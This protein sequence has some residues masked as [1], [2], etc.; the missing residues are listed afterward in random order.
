MIIKQLSVFLE[1]KSGRLTELTDVLGEAG[2]NLSA[3]SIAE[4]SEFGII[5]MVVSDPEKGLQVLK[6]N[7]FSVSLTDVACLSTPNQA[8]S[9]AR[10]LKILS[11]E[12][13]S[14]EYMYAFSMDERALVVI[15]TED[16]QKTINVLKRHEME[17]LQASELYNI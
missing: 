16:I 2:V 12:N 15:R 8:G 5:R 17:L 11:A 7:M 9:L 6:D 14:V 1:N 10:A 13:I 3:L 4:T